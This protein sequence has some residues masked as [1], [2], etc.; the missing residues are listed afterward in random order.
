MKGKAY[1]RYKDYTKAKRKRDI[2]RA[3][4][5]G[6]WPFY[7]NLHQYSK[8]KI[9]CS[10]PMCSPKTRNKGKRRY[11][12]GNYEKSI[13]YKISDQKKYDRMIEEMDGYFLF[14]DESKS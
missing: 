13:N 12:H 8:N 14:S 9:H 3:I 5:G 2:D 4:Y 1:H 7:G 11:K 6:D 10:C